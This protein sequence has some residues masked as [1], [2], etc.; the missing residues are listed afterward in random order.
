M[1]LTDW[2]GLVGVQ[3]AEGS[4]KIWL[5]RDSYN[6]LIWK[7]PANLIWEGFLKVWWG[8]VRM[9]GALLGSLVRVPC[10]HHMAETLLVDKIFRMLITMYFSGKR[11][12]LAV[13]KSANFI[14]GLC[15]SKLFPFTILVEKLRENKTVLSQLS[16]WSIFNE[17]YYICS[18]LRFFKWLLYTDGEFFTVKTEHYSCYISERD[19]LRSLYRIAWCFYFFAIFS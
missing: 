9:K 7:K 4:L 12:M 13:L 19:H 16:F 14:A 17:N 11:K 2:G 8:S 3:L 5:G 15:I 6:F 1:F 10:C 18:C